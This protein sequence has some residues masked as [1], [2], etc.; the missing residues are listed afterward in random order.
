MRLRG[1]SNL[2]ATRDSVA[3]VASWHTGKQF[4]PIL[5]PLPSAAHPGAHPGHRKSD[6]WRRRSLGRRFPRL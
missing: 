5:D 2:V 6:E 4:S 3:L 1:G